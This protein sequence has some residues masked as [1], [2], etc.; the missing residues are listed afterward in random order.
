MTKSY[1][2]LCS[3]CQIAG[4]DFVNFFGLFRKHELYGKMLEKNTSL[5]KQ[6]ML[7]YS[8]PDFRN[9]PPPCVRRRAHLS[10]RRAVG[11][12]EW[13]EGTQCVKLKLSGGFVCTPLHALKSNYS[14]LKL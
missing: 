10:E 8:Y 12:E 14:Y 5:I 13:G 4:E 7:S 9:V 6:F 11:K 2:T 1:L 3:K